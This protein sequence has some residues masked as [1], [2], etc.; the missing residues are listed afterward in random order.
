[1]RTEEGL[2]G[3]GQEGAGGRLQQL[4]LAI[5]SKQRNDV[6]P[7]VLEANIMSNVT[8]ELPPQGRSGRTGDHVACYRTDTTFH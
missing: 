6:P 5:T 4:N 1:M 7:F 2:S 3:E 8:S